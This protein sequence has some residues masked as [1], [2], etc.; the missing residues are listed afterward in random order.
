MRWRPSPSPLQTIAGAGSL[1]TAITSANAAAGTDT[2]VFNIAGAGAHT[3]SLTTALPTITDTVIL[4]ATTQSGYAAG[5]PGAVIV[6]DGTGAGAEASG[7][8]LQAS[9]STITGFR[10]QNFSQW[11]NDSITGT[12]IVIDGTTAG[13]DNNTNFSELSHEQ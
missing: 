4:D 8:V 9:N 10:I 3:I 12:G 2:I 13:G 6:L 5:S 11:D 7:F 1:R